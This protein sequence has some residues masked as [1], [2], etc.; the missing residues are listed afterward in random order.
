MK[1]SKLSIT[2]HAIL[3]WR[4]RVNSVDFTEETIKKCLEEARIIRKNE[5][6]PFPTPRIPNTVY[7]VKDNIMFILQP[8]AIKE[9]NLITVVNKSIIFGTKKPQCKKR[10][11]QKTNSD[12]DQ[13]PKKKYRR[14]KTKLNDV[15]E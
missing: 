2:D 9:F 7:A 14:S 8:V 5:S 1:F 15:L 13:K 3:R 11:V 12:Q 6:L 4:Q 10:I